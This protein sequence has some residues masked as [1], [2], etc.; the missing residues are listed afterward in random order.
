MT[1]SVPSMERGSCVLSGTLAGMSAK[2]CSC[3]WGRIAI[4][5]SLMRKLRPIKVESLAQ[6]PSS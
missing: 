4:P 6:Q 2:F 5:I 1:Q 3:P